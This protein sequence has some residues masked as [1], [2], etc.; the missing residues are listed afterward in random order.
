[1]TLTRTVTREELTCAICGKPGV[2]LDHVK[3]RSTHPQ[4]K[5]DPTNIIGLCP[6]CHQLKTDKRIKT[7]VVQQTSG[8]TT[9][10]PPHVKLYY[11]W[12]RNEKDAP[13]IV[14]AAR[15]N[16]RH[17]CLERVAESAAEDAEGSRAQAGAEDDGLKGAA[18]ESSVPPVSTKVSSAAPPASHGDAAEAHTL[19]TS[20]HSPAAPLSHDQRL[21]KAA[22]IRAAQKHRQWIAGDTANEW[23]AE[24]GEDF[25]N[26]YANEFGYAFPSLRN[27]MKVCAAIPVSLRRGD[28]L[29]FGHHAVVYAQNKEDIDAYLDRA[30]EED[31]N[32]T[33]LR[34]AMRAD[35]LLPRPE[36]K[37]LT[38]PEC[39]HEG[40]RSGFNAG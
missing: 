34:E 39:G 2:A 28:P 40:E 37:M 12:R 14:W 4:L 1:M 16:K 27:M 11:R 15:V 24:L 32:I 13:W 36:P 3:E 21:E 35:G 8:G 10:A 38:C 31:L 6:A 9:Q 7:E 23:E 33:R 20:L 25:W 22:S 5:D 29:S 19:S 17:K 18:F 26:L 30:V